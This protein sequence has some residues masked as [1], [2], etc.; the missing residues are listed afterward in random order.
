MTSGKALH[1]RLGAEFLRRIESGEW[2]EGVQVPSEARLCAEFGTS[3]GPVRQ[4]LAM[5][6][7]EGSL[8]GGRGRPPVAR[9]VARSQPFASLLSFTQWAR[10]I[11]R[12]PGQ[13]TVEVARRRAAPET[14]GRLGVEDG[15]TVVE[16]VRLRTLD[17]VP[18]ML[19]RS[20]FVWDV[21]RHLFDF[22]PDSG[23]LYEELCRRGAG[24]D[25]ARH[26]I[27]AIAAEPA[28][29]ELL[30]VAE[31]TPLLRVRRQT[32]CPDGE[33]LEF[34]DDR[35]LPSLTNFTIEN[36]AEGRT[37]AGRHSTGEEPEH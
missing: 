14:A 19:E 13:T 5:L 3:R 10:S 8:V 26:T 30:A 37:V 33:P 15:D 29:A 20:A 4:A 27:D 6:R 35:Y 2:P 24:L 18:A 12:L 1:E 9:K 36:T 22:D 28:D 25:H 21:G 23:S 34:S 7:Q 31:R 11:G 17:G 32:F 16:I